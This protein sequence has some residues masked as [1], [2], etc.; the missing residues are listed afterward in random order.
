MYISRETPEQAQLRLRQ[1]M[2]ESKLRVFSGLYAFEEFPLA[3]FPIELAADALAFVRD[4]DVWSAL[5][6]ARSAKQERLVIFSFHF[7]PG[8][9]NSGFVGWLA[10]RL[11]EAIGTGVMVVCGQNSE[12]GGIFD[13][14]GVPELVAADVLAEIQ[15]LLGR[16]APGVSD[17]GE[18]G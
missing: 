10:S 1:V 7:P 6:P 5:V 3:H 2:S 15:H 17:Q 14:W 13:Y 18:V 12:R 9:D 16:A 4:E 8:L 11:K